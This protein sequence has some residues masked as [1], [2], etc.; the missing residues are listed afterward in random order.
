MKIQILD[1]GTT[2]ITGDEQL[3]DNIWVP[4][5]VNVRLLPGMPITRRIIEPMSLREAWIISLALW[6]WLKDH[7]KQHPKDYPWFDMILMPKHH[8][9]FCEY[10][11]QN[12]IDCSDCPLSCRLHDAPWHELR[13]WERKHFA[14]HMIKLCKKELGI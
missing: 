14:K 4:A 8:E 7:P 12:K 1:I 5:P 13:G 11:H 10:C 9:P 6:I 2:T 3:V